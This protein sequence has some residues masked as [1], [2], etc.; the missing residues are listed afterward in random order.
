MHLFFRKIYF[1][2]V[3]FPSLHPWAEDPAHKTK[4]PAHVPESTLTLQPGDKLA[5]L[6]TEDFESSI[7][8]P[9]P[10][11]RSYL[12]K[13]THEE[14]ASGHFSLRLESP[15]ADGKAHQ[16]IGGDIVR[17]RIH[18]DKMGFRLSMN[19][20]LKKIQNGQL[21][22]R[23]RILDKDENRLRTIV[24]ENVYHADENWRVLEHER[25]INLEHASTDLP[26]ICV[27]PSMLVKN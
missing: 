23:V 17:M 5:K 4:T 10:M 25:W 3:I 12:F 15:L 24:L 6:W 11:N 2:L 20:W 16:I 1:I 9:S 27:P 8:K 19:S 18:P 26:P 7:A 13:R 22:L 21:I 14:A